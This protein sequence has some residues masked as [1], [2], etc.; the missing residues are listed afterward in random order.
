MGISEAR[1]L[2]GDP[3]PRPRP[4]NPLDGRWGSARITPRLP[5]RRPNRGKRPEGFIRDFWRNL[6]DV[7]DLRS[8]EVSWRFKPSSLEIQVLGVKSRFSLNLAS[9][10]PFV[11]SRDIGSSG[12]FGT[13]MWGRLLAMDRKCNPSE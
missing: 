13:V 8:R 4:Q 3:R 6:V 12:A 7:L 5:S 11:A 10:F 2:V 9:Y 1:G